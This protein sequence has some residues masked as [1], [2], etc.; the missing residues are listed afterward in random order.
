MK[1]SRVPHAKKRQID[2]E[3]RDGEGEGELEQMTRVIV[4]QQLSM[5]NYF[6]RLL[7]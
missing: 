6:T 3:I 2:Q 5:S 7:W 1:I 4:H